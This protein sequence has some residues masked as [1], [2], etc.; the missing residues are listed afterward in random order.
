MY[1][2]PKRASEVVVVLPGGQPAAV[3]GR[4]QNAEWLYVA[5]PPASTFRGW[6]PA[7]GLRLEA[8][9]LAALPLVDAQAVTTATT[10]RTSDGALPDPAL[11]EV[12]VLPGGQLAIDIR[13]LGPGALTEVTLMLS[14]TR[15]SPEGDEVIEVLRIGPATLPA[16]GRATIVVL[17]TITA[18]GTYRIELDP[19]REAPDVQHSNNLLEASLAP[20]RG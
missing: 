16:G 8:A 6:A 2:R 15:V 5:T 18:S 13:N 9:V 7:G 20:G 4:S 12:R 19:G 17:V 10:T 11:S 14:V 3:T 1:A